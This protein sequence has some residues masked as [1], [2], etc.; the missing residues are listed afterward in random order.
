MAKKKVSKAVQTRTAMEA[1]QNGMVQLR[2]KIAAALP[3]HV[4]ADK[5]ERVVMMAV[6]NNEYLLAADRGTLY[7]A[8]LQCASD[9]LLPDGR[10]AALVAY[11]NKVQYLPMVAG[12]LKRMRNSGDLKEISAHCVRENDEFDYQL[13]D[14]ESIFH[15]PLIGGDDRGEIIM[16]YCVAKTNDGGIF[17][18]FMDEAAIAKV[19]SVSQAGSKNKGPWKD[20]PEE[21]RKKSVI[22]RI[23]KRMPSMADMRELLLRGDDTDF[24]IKPADNDIPAPAAE[25]GPS[26]LKAAMAHTGAIE[27]EAEEVP[28]ED[29]RPAEEGDIANAETTL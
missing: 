17:R 10:D 11:G 20:W 6:Q 14:N 21:M 18:E 16:T 4:S 25:E 2:P 12:I 24:T 26:R 28:P 7:T 1:F 29:E 22:R 3:S 19:R 8:T 9:G 5:L 13:G 27:G 15:R 23:A